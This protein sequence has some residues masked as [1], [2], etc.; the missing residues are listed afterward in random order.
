MRIKKQFTTEQLEKIYNENWYRAGGE[1]IC[2]VCG[3][4]YKRHEDI[5]YGEFLYLTVLC[6]GEL[7]KL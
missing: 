6:N 4:E 3:K 5:V 7:V 2:E 1:C